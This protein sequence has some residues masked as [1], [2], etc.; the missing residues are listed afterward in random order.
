MTLD[1]LWKEKKSTQTTGMTLDD[2]WNDKTYNRA[3]EIG[4]ERAN[5]MLSSL[6]NISDRNTLTKYYQAYSED[7]ERAAKNQSLEEYFKD[8]IIL[9]NLRSRLKEEATP[10]DYAIDLKNE[11]GGNIRSAIAGP[12]QGIQA[13]GS[14]LQAPQIYDANTLYK[15]AKLSPDTD[16]AKVGTTPV[17][18]K[19]TAVV[20]LDTLERL[21]QQFPNDKV[22]TDVYETVKRGNYKGDEQ[23][24]DDTVAYINNLSRTTD[25]NNSYINR[26]T[27]DEMQFLKDLKTKETLSYND[28]QRFFLDA[29]GVIANMAPSIATAF[30]TGG[31]G[32]LAN[33]SKVTVNALAQAGALGSMG[34]SVFG[35]T[36]SNT[37]DQGYSYNKSLAYAGS[38]A[39]VEVLTEL[40]GG[41]AINSA[42][43][44]RVATT[45]L[46]KA[47][48]NFV[49]KHNITDAAAK[50]LLSFG[51][52]IAGEALEEVLS[53]SF[54][55]IL[56]SL[57]LDK[58]I[59]AEEYMDGIFE[60]A[61]GSIIPSL[62]LGGFG[63]VQNVK[64]IDEL[65][66][67]LDTSI[68][69][70]VSLEEPQKAA[71]LDELQ[72]KASDARIGLT[73][74]WEN[75]EEEV[76]GKLTDADIK[77]YKTLIAAS[78]VA[79]NPTLTEQEKNSVISKYAQKVGGTYNI[80]NQTTAEL[81]DTYKERAVK[82]KTL[83]KAQQTLDNT[84]AK[85][86]DIK[87][88]TIENNLNRVQQVAKNFLERNMSKGNEVIYVH[89]DSD[90]ILTYGFIEG[91]DGNI[92]I[93]ADLD[94]KATLGAMFHERGHQL[95]VSNPELYQDFLDLAKITD[96]QIE[97]YKEKVNDKL[98]PDE[99][100]EEMFGDYIGAIMS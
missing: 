71:M 37:L 51:G 2:L 84:V 92:Y 3:S 69:K 89:P 48:A 35:N 7:M 76:L 85:N 44:G 74:N 75:I 68:R 50:I 52:D 70:S 93:N 34:A 87:G 79:S 39:A 36:F 98:T 33:A 43:F 97:T 18:G 82:Y 73:K 40:I 59:N 65:E 47:T 15:I 19:N 29:T 23:Y 88:I 27:A 31:A 67:A 22:V 6:N 4:Q 64:Y 61:V 95:K 86:P 25:Y 17:N 10:V 14:Y 66:K 54:D 90:E 32:Q 41:D 13:G 83:A 16:P 96:E 12:F 55:P 99:V 49:A 63:R 21:H 8:R 30:V 81:V 5:S 11:I 1:D 38:T 77:N 58:N 28:G 57:I 56:G 91:D 60:D 80:G 53:A 45:P 72:K 46:G 94:T 9:N 100:R 78:R 62:V 20:A 42:I 26:H 24:F